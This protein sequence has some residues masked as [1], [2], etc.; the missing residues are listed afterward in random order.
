MA[1]RHIGVEMPA[2]C[3]RIVRAAMQRDDDPNPTIAITIP[4]V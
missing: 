3:T 2:L 4:S 1:A